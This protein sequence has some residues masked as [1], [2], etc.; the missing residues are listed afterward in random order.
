MF[1]V[2][3]A[4]E[5]SVCM[6]TRIY[7]IKEYYVVQVR[8]NLMIRESVTRAHICVCVVRACDYHLCDR[9]F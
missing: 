6:C 5:R 9:V 7:N 8:M 2:I 3:D 4:I 1:D